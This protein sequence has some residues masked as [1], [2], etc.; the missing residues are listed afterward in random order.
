V[1]LT[2][3]NFLPRG[4][5]DYV[6]TDFDELIQDHA[7]TSVDLRGVGSSAFTG[8]N[9][10]FYFFGQD[11]WKVT[12]NL[13]LNLGLRYEFVTLPRDS[14]LQALNAISSIPGVLEFGVPKTDKNNFAPPP[15]SVRSKAALL[16]SCRVLEIRATVLLSG[17]RLLKTKP[18]SSGRLNADLQAGKGQARA[19]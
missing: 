16:P 8:N 5:G 10:R 17:V 4:R 6:Y 15:K 1:L 13:T 2:T 7:P 3:S 14:N 12:Q 9:K 11:D 18:S 19:F